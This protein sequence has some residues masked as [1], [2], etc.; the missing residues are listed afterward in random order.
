MKRQILSIILSTLCGLTGSLII[1]F[2][3]F[4]NSIFNIEH[5]AALFLF[6]GFYGSVF[7]A[8]QNY[9]GKK[10]LFASLIIVVVFQILL[11]GK[12]VST[13][14][15]LRDLILISSLFVSV[16]AFFKVSNSYFDKSKSLL[17]RTIAFSVIY[18]FI[19]F[20][21]GGILF[22]L[23]SAR[24]SPDLS[25]MIFYAQYAFLIGFGISLGSLSYYFYIDSSI[26]K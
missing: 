11:M 4:Q 7:F 13:S 22:V 5:P 3:F 10:E 16:L 9:G 8:L 23:Q 15:Y 25:I 12:S 1:G 18:S 21:L 2:V 17:Y 26:K 20:I 14:Y 6:Y 24:F 19:N